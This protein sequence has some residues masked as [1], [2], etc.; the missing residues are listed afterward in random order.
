[1]FAHSFGG[2]ENQGTILPLRFFRNI[3]LQKDFDQFAN[4]FLG[5]YDFYQLSHIF[6]CFQHVWIPD[7]HLVRVVQ[8]G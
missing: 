8:K 2:T 3:K 6:V 7:F 4:L 5:V 1:L